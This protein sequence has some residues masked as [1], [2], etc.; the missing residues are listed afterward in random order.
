MPVIA[1]SVTYVTVDVFTHERFSGNQLAVIP[2]ARGLTDAQMQQIAA[3]FRY[4][5]VTFVLPPENPENSARVRI[6]TPTM[7]VPFAGHPNVG[8]AFVLGNR[9]DIFGKA[10]AHKL[11]FEETA[12]LVEAELVR[13]ADGRVT[14]A[15]IRAPQGLTVGSEVAAET[16][17]ACAA[18]EAG[19][20]TVETHHP[21]IVSVGLPFAIAQ[22]KN[23]DILARACPNTAAFAAAYQTYTPAEEQ[24]ALFL[25]VSNPRK[26]LQFRARMFA[27]LDNVIEDP[28]TGSA[29]GALAAYL[30]S[31]E[32][33]SDGTYDIV[34]EQG[35]EMGRRSLISVRIVKAAGQIETV[36]ISGD[37]VAVMQG[38]IALSFAAS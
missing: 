15:G 5:E 22:V 26:P 18:L 4:S 10:V 28:A 24:F 16:I 34:I 37:C 14:G 2:D 30:V 35:V 13:N 38:V 20:I 23:L 9:A 7:E 27:P 32:P 29:S 3:E 19:D 6:F 31:L 33:E 25:Y 11:R 21:I 17:A 12:G 36:R 1:P 8:T